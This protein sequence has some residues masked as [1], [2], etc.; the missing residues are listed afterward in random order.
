MVFRV[1]QLT[2]KLYIEGQVSLHELIVNPVDGFLYSLDIDNDL[3][4]KNTY[5]I[6]PENLP[7]IYLPETDSYYEMSDLNR[8]TVA[9]DKLLIFQKVSG[10]SQLS[11]V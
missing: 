6:L 11:K 4:V 1:A 5:L 10:E 7:A 8:E 2:L 3:Q 9:E